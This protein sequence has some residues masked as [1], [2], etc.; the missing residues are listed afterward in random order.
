MHQPHWLRHNTFHQV[1]Q[2]SV[3]SP[4]PGGTQKNYLHKH[5]KINVFSEKS[6][7]RT[8]T[9]THPPGAKN[10]QELKHENPPGA[11][12]PGQAPEAAS[13]RCCIFLELCHYSQRSSLSGLASTLTLGWAAQSHSEERAGHSHH[14]YGEL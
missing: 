8:H 9:H 13:G 10:S 5:L 12:P 6:R 14:F 2:H 3:L 4:F 7:A 1:S 11:P